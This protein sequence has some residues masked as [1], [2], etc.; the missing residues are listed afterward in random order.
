SEMI[1]D[2]DIQPRGVFLSYGLGPVTFRGAVFHRSHI[3]HDRSTEAG[4]QV[5]LRL[6]IAAN[7]TMEAD[8][9]FLAFNALDQFQPGMERQNSVQVVDGTLR[10]QSAFELAIARLRADYRGSTRRP[11]GIEFNF[12]QNFGA[13]NQQRAFEVVTEV[14]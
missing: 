5:A 4:G 6:P 11:L 7:W 3:H 14:G 13:A 1:W 10:Y 8:A 2:R 12:V 9:G